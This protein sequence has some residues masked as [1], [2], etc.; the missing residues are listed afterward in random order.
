MGS[1]Q[2]VAA[3]EEETSCAFKEMIRNNPLTDPN[4]YY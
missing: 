2:S 1:K 4:I 3:T